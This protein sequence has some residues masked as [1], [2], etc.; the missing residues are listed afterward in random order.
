M[1]QTQLIDVNLIELDPVT[2]V[3]IGPADKGEEK[4][5][6][7]LAADIDSNGLMQPI[8][9]R[10]NP[11]KPGYYLIVFGRRRL[12][13]TQ[14]LEKKQVE[15][16]VDKLDDDEAWRQAVS[17]N[18]KRKNFTTLQEALLYADVAAKHPDWSASAIGELFGVSKAQVSEHLKL[19]EQPKQVQNDVHSGKMSFAAAQ[20]LWANVHP[21]KVEKVAA[22]AKE[23]AET[24][25]KKKQDKQ[26]KGKGK[27]AAPAEPKVE[28]KHVEKAAK[29]LE[30]EKVVK[31]RGRGALLEP[32]ELILEAADSYSA[33]IVAF[34]KYYVKAYA[35][36]G[37]TAKGVITKLD[38]VDEVVNT[39][40]AKQKANF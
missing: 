18:L 10:P 17:E 23:L 28:R 15:A 11:A 2:D 6:E 30:A 25:G 38:V 26:A 9:V 5:I 20:E 24:E 32:F 1:S 33:E 14:F 34:C 12:E 27:T 40:K 37:G 19:L 29:E 36:G 31:P 7:Q 21:E 4:R 16:F 22:K 39:K 8:K 3:R 35:T 13:A